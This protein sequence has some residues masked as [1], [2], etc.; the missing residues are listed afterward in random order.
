MFL[1]NLCV[2]EMLGQMNCQVKAIRGHLGHIL[3]LQRVLLSDGPFQ[4]IWCL[5][6]Y[7]ECVPSLCPSCPSM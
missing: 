7:L 2:W 1:S 5:S 3:R 6:S 4:A